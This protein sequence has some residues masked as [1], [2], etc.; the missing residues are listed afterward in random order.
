[1]TWD[2]YVAPFSYG[3]WIAVAI[4]ACSISVFLALTNYGHERDQRLTVPAVLFFVFG[5]LCQQGEASNS[6]VSLVLLSYIFAL[7][8]IFLSS[9]ALVLF[10]DLYNPPIPIPLLNFVYLFI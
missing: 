5:C 9:L 1:M 8:N 6:Y 4:A 10:A 2:R 7:I 3:L